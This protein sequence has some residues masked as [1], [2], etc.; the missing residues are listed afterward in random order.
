M[1]FSQKMVVDPLRWHID[2]GATCEALY[3]TDARVQ[4]VEQYLNQRDVPLGGTLLPPEE[5]LMVLHKHLIEVV[6]NTQL[7]E[8]NWD[9]A[10]YYHYREMLTHM[11]IRQASPLIPIGL[12]YRVL[13]DRVPLCE[14]VGDVATILLKAS[15][16]RVT[17]VDK[18][19]LLSLLTVN[20]EPQLWVD[21]TDTRAADC[22]QILHK[23]HRLCRSSRMYHTGHRGDPIHVSTLLEQQL[24]AP[25]R[26]WESYDNSKYTQHL[27]NRARLL[28]SYSWLAYTHYN[29]ILVH[30]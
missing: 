13:E 16:S 9:T 29:P 28:L 15:D 12:I 30:K 2:L 8:M 1:P 3:A 26:K 22:E 19:L 7:T 25:N 20:T 23:Y 21:A 17:F 4:V 14:R 18:L 10:L 5:C 24:L 6:F 11:V 27:V